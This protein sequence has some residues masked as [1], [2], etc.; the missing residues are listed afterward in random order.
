MQTQTPTQ[1]TLA[2]TTL[3]YFRIQILSSPVI[4]G[5]VGYK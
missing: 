5:G 4:A 1:Y 2:V 3:R